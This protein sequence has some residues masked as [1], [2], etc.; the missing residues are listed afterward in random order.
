MPGAGVDGVPVPL[1]VDA[2]TRRYGSDWA[3]GGLAV[4][5]VVHTEM[6]PGG[7]N[8]QLSALHCLQL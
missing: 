7:S 6:V 8:R 1:V 3:T 4:V 2:P 5:V